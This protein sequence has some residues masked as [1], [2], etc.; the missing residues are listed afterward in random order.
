MA[1]P[2]HI[3][4]ADTAKSRHIGRWIGAAALFSV[5]GV[6][7]FV[8]LVMRTNERADLIVSVASLERPA[9]ILVDQWGV[10]HIYTPGASTMHSWLKG[11]MQHAIGSSRLT[12]G[13][14]VA[15]VSLPK[16]LGRHTSIRIRRPDSFCIAGI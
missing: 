10:P 3:V 9:E 2:S 12:C 13:V 14:D 11:S 1:E 6:S 16:F 4:T 8:I 7:L 5:V 15:L